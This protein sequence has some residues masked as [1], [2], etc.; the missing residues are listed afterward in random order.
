MDDIAISRKSERLQAIINDEIV[1]D[2]Q[3]YHV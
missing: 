2:W 3:S 1:Y